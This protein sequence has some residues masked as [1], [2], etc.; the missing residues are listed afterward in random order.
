MIDRE[1]SFLKSEYQQRLAYQGLNWEQFLNT[2]GGEEKLT[3]NLVQEAKVR[4]KN[5][6]IIDKISK[7][8]NITV[9]QSDFT[10]KLS[11]LSSA[12]GVGPQE[13]V[14]QFGH[15]PNFLSSLSQQIIND[16]VRDFL[17][18]NN[19]FEYVET[20]KKEKVEA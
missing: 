8:E 10:T 12:Y 18:D 14:K 3:D 1:V 7:E 6:L 19:K 5:S 20:E 11:Q 17:V 13:M 15:N 9:E 2:Q 16:K 4:I